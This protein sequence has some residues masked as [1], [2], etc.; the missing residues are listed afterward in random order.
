MVQSFEI[1][2]L[3]ISIF[4][5]IVYNSISA[6]TG[7]IWLILV[8]LFLISSGGSAIPEI[9][10]CYSFFTSVISFK[11]YK[12]LDLLLRLIS[13]ETHQPISM[14]ARI[15]IFFFTFK[16]KSVNFSS[17]RSLR[18]FILSTLSANNRMIKNLRFV[19]EW[20]K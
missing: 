18:N 3:A 4:H 2:N 16:C 9:N 8:N 15:S 1:A 5:L 17:N 6:L 7:T 14:F 20:A 11:N 19:Y 13:L 10:W 12:S